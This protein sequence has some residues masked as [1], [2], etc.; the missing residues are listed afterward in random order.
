MLADL[1]I[2]VKLGGGFGLV[3]LLTLGVGLAGWNGLV[4]VEH[5]IG[6][7]DGIGE[8]AR[9]A[10]LAHYY[11]TAFDANH[12]A[13]NVNQVKDHVTKLLAKAQVV[14][15]RLRDPV[16]QSDIDEISK[17]AADYNTAFQGYVESQVQRDAAVDRMRTVATQVVEEIDR[18]NENQLTQL[19]DLRQDL[20]Q[21]QN[22]RLVA[23]D[24]ANN[25]TRIALEARAQ[26]LLVTQNM[27]D[28]THLQEWRAI[29]RRFLDLLEGQG[30]VLKSMG[31]VDRAKSIGVDYQRYIT[32]FE[33]YLKSKRQED[34]DLA[35][36]AATDTFQTLEKMRDTMEVTSAAKAKTDDVSM[37]AKLANGRD[38]SLVVKNFLEVR[39]SAKEYIASSER[40]WADQV[41]KN[42]THI[43]DTLNSLLSGRLKREQ[44]IK[45]VRTAVADL[46]SYREAFRSF[47]ALTDRQVADNQRSDQASAR[48]AELT[49]KTE[50]GQHTKME[51]EQNS[52]E[53]FILAAG[54]TALLLGVFV[55]FLLARL[56]SRAAV[57][58]LRFTEAVAEG[59]LRVRL[60]QQGRDEL[61]RLLLALEGM[62]QRLA[63]VVGQV[64]TTA[65][66]L[67]A[68][69]AQLSST[70]QSL[71]QASSEQAA[72]VEETSA[73]LEQMSASIGQNSDNAVATE[74]VAMKSAQEAVESGK[75][76]SE[77][78]D[79][80]RKIAERIGFIE[81]IAYKTNLLALNAAIEAARAG[82]H[83]KGFAV[84]A[85]EVRKLAENSQVAAREISGLA[86]SS[87]AVAERA[88]GLLATLVPGIKKTAELVQEI[89]AASRE[90]T[91]GVGQVNAAMGQVDQAVQQNAAA[92]EELA[93]TASEVTNQAEEL[94]Q[95]MAFFQLDESEEKS[96]AVSHK[97]EAR[98]RQ[99][100]S[101][102]MT[103]GRMVM[104]RSALTRSATSKKIEV[105]SDFKNF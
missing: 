100:S 17:S 41:E 51:Q 102:K 77:T 2:A 59:N 39:V 50:V 74:G 61:G 94:N 8:I 86:K 101:G 29:N 40:K 78:V 46:E 43:L 84:V 68:A 24:V 92:A 23:T 72:S 32:S 98:P 85:A 13:A 103:S 91:G 104:T 75:A 36:K 105:P 11:D 38:S 62:R 35:V 57:N 15:A 90:Q 63:G 64:R 49:D 58:G 76:V 1:R 3:L 87:V 27:G 88:G 71:S 30:E 70:A 33:T 97:E 45:S 21:S 26:R 19:N 25:L 79:A 69:A 54:G 47:V 52:A 42:L 56:I 5:R 55:A 7:L 14:R 65:G 83:G 99:A 48:V 81:D 67:S 18:V 96:L 10:L 73:S 89:A 53:R 80:M 4:G 9:H 44:N 66:S 12:T 6:T 93:A 20:A 22:N 31:E 16:D 37:T 95:L 60:E 28:T 34:L 82:E